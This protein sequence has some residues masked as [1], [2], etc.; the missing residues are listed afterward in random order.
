[1]HY[2]ISDIFKTYGPE[3]IK[4]HNLSKDRMESL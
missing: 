2:K 3:Y 4:N 1:M